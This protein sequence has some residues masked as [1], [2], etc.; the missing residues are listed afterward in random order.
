[1]KI[2]QKSSIN[3]DLFEKM[4]YNVR[5][6]YV[7]KV[8]AITGYRPE[9]LS[10]SLS[11]GGMSMKNLEK[12][13]RA[14]MIEALDND[15]STF[16]SGMALGTD[17]LFAKIAVELRA[18][19]KPLGIKFIAALPCR[20]HDCNWGSRE[21]ELC[22]ELVETADEVVLVSD[23]HYYDGCMAKRNRYLV[24]SCDELLAIYDGQRG[25]TMQTVNYAKKKGIQVSII[26]PSRNKIVVLREKSANYSQIELS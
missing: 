21:R 12:I 22:R 10:V 15:F 20:D 23:S 8:L 11:Q 6:N 2:Y 7:N 13:L 24:D 1:M 5:M 25:G 4:W 16:V 19:Y 26:D 9:K 14:Q 17:L 18:K 3:I